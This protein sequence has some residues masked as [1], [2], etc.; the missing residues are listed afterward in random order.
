MTDK[1][2]TIKTIALV[3]ISIVFLF[4]FYNTFFKTKKN[5]RNSAL[6][7]QPPKVTTVMP[8]KIKPLHTGA[9]TL[10]VS[11]S[12]PAGTDDFPAQPFKPVIRDIF[13]PAD[14]VK[15][16][17]KKEEEEPKPIVD[18]VKSLVKKI[19]EPLPL[20]DQEKSSISQDLHFKGSVLSSKGAVAIIND[21]FIHVGD[22]VN[23]Y[24]VASISA[25]QVFID[26]GRGTIILEIMKN[27]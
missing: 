25:Q 1:K 8:E 7:K 20:S 21:E 22:Y 5:S 15:F 19:V 24:K 18:A 13:K 14:N 2:K 26:T 27:E 6:K 11:G 4:M 23:G 16:V 10:Q 3:L 17:P 9:V 12:D